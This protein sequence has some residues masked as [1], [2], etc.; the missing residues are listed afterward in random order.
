M[1]QFKVITPFHSPQ[2]DDLVS[3]PSFGNLMPAPASA[4][5]RFRNS[6]ED[7]E[8]MPAAINGS[9]SSTAEPITSAATEPK[10]RCTSWRRWEGGVSG[11][12]E[13]VF[14]LLGGNS[15]GGVAGGNWNKRAGGWD[16]CKRKKIQS[17][18]VVSIFFK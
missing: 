5:R 4:L 2:Q 13:I 16:K 15:L 14:V 18:L 8:S 9:S 7:R 17:S 1:Y 11:L 12:F 3:H 10:G 6:T